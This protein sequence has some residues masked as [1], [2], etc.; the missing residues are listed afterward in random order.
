MEV[1]EK[2]IE[3]KIETKN[4][5][6]N[7]AKHWIGGDWLDSEKHEESIN[8]ATGELIGWYADGGQKE[9]EIA[10]NAALK[11]FRETTWKEDH[12]WR[13]KVLLA[14]ADKIEAKSK[15]LIQILGLESGKI[16]AEASMEVFAAPAFLRYW[17]GKTF[18][19]GRAGEARPG[20]FSFTIR[21]AVGVA[22]I[23]VPFNAP[24]ALTMRALA[25]A[26]AAGTTTVVKLPGVT[27]QTNELLCKI[28]SETP[29][30]PKGA[31]NVITESGS[32]AASS[33]VQS[34][35]V[36]VI[37][38][39]GS[40][41]TGRA[42]VAAGAAHLKRF[43]LE[44]GGKTPMIVFKDADLMTAIF[45]MEKAITIFSGQFCMTGSRILVQREVA[46]SI[47]QGLAERLSKV[48]IGTPSDPSSEMGTMRDKAN[49]QRVNQ[50]VEEA[51]AAGAKAIVRGGPITDGQLAK[52]AFYR[53][54]LL[55]VTDPEL[56]IVQQEVFGPVA[57]LQVFDTE[58]EA[59]ALA[60]NSEYGLAASI[61]T[62]DIDRPWRVA[63]AIQAGTIW[64][65][66]F[67]QVFPQFEEGGYKQ[68]G[69]G[70]LN[71]ETALDDFLEYKHISFNPG[72]PGSM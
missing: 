41:Q 43:S 22:G 30:L 62:R 8:P 57:T 6:K 64:I 58:A 44:L 25:P 59:I 23:I 27:A 35:N 56:P 21:E 63:K 31:I 72:V 42:I 1:I 40:T 51:L 15:D 53:P 60:N 14:M 12:A 13:A 10:I 24:V 45:T 26:L 3:L 4:E 65:N 48:K 5:L 49:V 7:R 11:T 9:A 36:P 33:L 70:R 38:F 32:E 46:D 37:S 55:E 47:R 28:I 20:S 34:A 19:A 66:T 18:T 52:G 29:G 16:V 39:T 71:G 68:S 50:M 54:T 67:A 69:M 17:A 2:G 61:W